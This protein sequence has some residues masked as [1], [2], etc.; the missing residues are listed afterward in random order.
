MAENLRVTPAIEAR[1]QH[2]CDRHAALVKQ[3]GDPASA[4]MPPQE[5]AKLN[6]EASDLEEVVIMVEAW[7]STQREVRLI[8]DGSLAL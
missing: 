6:K 2:I 7:R 5:M 3:L 1:L 8:D 4:S